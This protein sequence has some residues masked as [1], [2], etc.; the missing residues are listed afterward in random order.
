MPS[1]GETKKIGYPDATGER[2]KFFHEYTERGVRVARITKLMRQFFAL[3]IVEYAEKGEDDK[4]GKDFEH[5]SAPRLAVVQRT[6]ATFTAPFIYLISLIHSMVY[7]IPKKNVVKILRNDKKFQTVTKE[8][9]K[10]SQLL[11]D[12]D[13]KKDIT[14]AE[15]KSKEGYKE[16]QSLLKDDRL[17]KT[18]R[19]KRSM[20]ESGFQTDEINEV[21]NNCSGS[22]VQFVRKGLLLGGVN[23]AKRWYLDEKMR[24]RPVLTFGDYLSLIQNWVKYMDDNPFTGILTRNGTDIDDIEVC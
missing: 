12:I 18:Q 21:L 20:I 19:F 9:K 16:L 13:E 3:K 7:T 11:R 8:F 23:V 4:T 10:V 1:S 5:G 6:W 2:L 15:L 24:A 17:K 22:P 14:E